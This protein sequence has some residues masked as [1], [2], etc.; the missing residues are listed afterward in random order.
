MGATHSK[1]DS[2]MTILSNY[3]NSIS[4]NVVN[5][6]SA[7]V[8]TS[9]IVDVECSDLVATTSQTLCSTANIAT[10][11][12]ATDTFSLYLE[13]GY[14]Q[15]DAQGMYDRIMDTYNKSSSCV[16]C[17]AENINQED[18]RSITIDD[19]TVNN[20][21][22]GIKEKVMKD[23]KTITNQET[24]GGVTPTK[25]QVDAATRISE[26]IDNIIKTSVVN[27][28]M[29]VFSASNVIQATNTSI[30]NINQKIAGTVVAANLISNAISANADVMADIRTLL[31]ASQ[32]T[33]GTKLFTWQFTVLILVFVF[34]VGGF[35][36]LRSRGAQVSRGQSDD[37]Y[38]YMDPGESQLDMSPDDDYDQDN[39]YPME[40]A[41]PRQRHHHH[42]N[43]KKKH[44]RSR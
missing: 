8:S 25:A 20:I 41:R 40:S 31:D 44:R 1:N 27:E 6:Y 17:S 15:E 37:Q 38:Q 4:T 34:L 11:K 36:I 29:R 16:A 24:T 32:E 10:Q 26:N 23:L 19:K 12:L 5:K 33:T 2:T 22:S 39:Q 21:T 35:V 18:T 7:S 42:H 14:N 43:S 28:T 13:K 30:R 9:N 3:L